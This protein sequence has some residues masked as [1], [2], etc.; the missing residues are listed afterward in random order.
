MPCSLWI[1]CPCILI[2]E[3]LQWYFCMLVDYSVRVKTYQ[4]FLALLISSDLRNVNSDTAPSKS[5]SIISVF[6]KSSLDFPSFLSIAYG[7]MFTTAPPSTIIF[8]IGLPSTCPFKTN[9]LR[10]RHFLFLA[11]H[12]LLVLIIHHY[13]SMK[14]MLMDTID[15]PGSGSSS[16]FAFTRHI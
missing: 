7:M 16:S 13:R 15:D 8:A 14:T 5:L 10:R 4:A 9:A 3:V 2:G 11:F 6:V 1:R 12:I